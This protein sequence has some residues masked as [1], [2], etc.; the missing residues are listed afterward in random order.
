MPFVRVLRDK[1]GYETTYLMHW[2]RDA[3][4]PRS[5]I[6]YAFR[7][8]GGASVGL[9]ALEPERQ[10]EIEEAYPGIDFQWKA[11]VK[12]QQVV[13][14]APEPKWLRKRRRTRREAPVAP[15][16]PR[17]APA[18]AAGGPTLLPPVPSV[19]EGET[20]EAQIAFL[21][22]WYP[23]LRERVPK[24]TADPA[25][26]EALLALAERLNPAAWTDA[27][28]IATG[29]PLAAEALERLSK[30]FA[31]RRSSRRG[32]RKAGSGPRASPAPPGRCPPR[33]RPAGRRARQR[34]PLPSPA[35]SPE[36]SVGVRRRR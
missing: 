36:S 11:L 15:N 27:D 31:R 12:N 28:E 25:R 19:L 14:V 35:T 18:R 1:H 26:Q 24:G 5:S 6:L 9:H 32:G 3:Q 34:S 21:S 7:T 22:E 2:F 30:V 8:P 33:D 17:P 29:L 16:G 23:R 4:P 13:E 20:R 10:R